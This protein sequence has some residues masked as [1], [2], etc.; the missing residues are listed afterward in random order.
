MRSALQACALREGDIDGIDV[1]RDQ[2]AGDEGEVR[3]QF[4]GGVDDTGELPLAEEG[5]EMQ[6]AELDDAKALEVLGEVG[7]GDLD[8]LDLE[9]GASDSRAVA[10]ND[11][12]RGDGHFSG[13]DD[14]LAAFW[15]VDGG[16]TAGEETSDVVQSDGR[17]GAET[18]EEGDDF[19]VLDVRPADDAGD[20]DR[21]TGELREGAD[22]K[23]DREKRKAGGDGCGDG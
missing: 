9:V 7:D 17:G 23:D 3:P 20:E 21:E 12:R 6:V 15:L 13:I 8:F 1:G 5:S 18:P 22:E 10:G 2:V 19:R 14:Q 16:D 4:V 11:E